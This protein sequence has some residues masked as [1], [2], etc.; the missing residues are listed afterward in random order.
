MMG[1]DNTVEEKCFKTILYGGHPLRQL[2]VRLDPFRSDTQGRISK[3]RRDAVR[4]RP[5]LTMPIRN[6][7]MGLVMG[8][9][10]YPSNR[11]RT[12]SRLPIIGGGVMPRRAAGLTALSVK[13]MSKPGLF[14]DG[15]GLYLQVTTTGAKSWIFRF[16]LHGRRRDMGLGGVDAVPLSDARERATAAKRLVERGIDPIEARKA[17]LEAAEAASNAGSSKTFRDAV[18]AFL[19]ANEARWRNSKHRAQW[20]STLENYA[21][22]KIGDLAVSDVDDARVIE[23]LTPIWGLKT[24]TATRLR[25][26]IERVLDFAA[27]KKWRSGLNPAR[28]SGHLEHVFPRKSEIATVR[29]HPSMPYRNIPAF[30]P[31]LQIQDGMGARALELTILCA[32]RT[33]ETLGATWAEIDFERRL[34]V[35]PSARMKMGRQHRIPLSDPAIAL[36]RKLIAVQENDFLFPGQRPNKPLSNMAMSMV[37][38]RL[39]LGHLTTHGFRATFRTWAGEE[40]ATPEQIMEA[41][42]AHAKGDKVAEAYN[43]GDLLDKRRVLMRLWGEFCTGEMEAESV[44]TV[45]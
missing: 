2:P 18:D 28:W 26:R 37:L 33:S 20:R 42:L 40:T 8:R 16:K 32:T 27:V 39:K 30:W 25:G 23:V 12:V 43:R 38:R 22:P 13:R 41:A 45:G 31:R 44:A 24:E 5:R 21:F 29:K 10:S 6:L 19:V 17:A 36:L 7:M 11:R 4:L 35:I 1:I 15:G 3:I 14:A 34:W 9:A